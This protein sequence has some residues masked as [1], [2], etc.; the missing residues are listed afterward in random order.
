MSVTWIY[1]TI[2]RASVLAELADGFQKRQALDIADRAADFGYHKVSV[3]LA[4]HAADM[5]L[6]FV[7]DVR[8]DLHGRAQVVAP[9]LFVDHRLVDAPC[10][11]VGVARAVHIQ[12]P[13]VVPQ[14]QVG[15]RAVVGDEHLAVL[16]G[17]HRARVDIDIG[18][19]L[20]GGDR[21]APAAQE[22][23]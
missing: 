1:I 12:K 3:L 16:V 18:I 13:L 6:D 14:V 19:H 23:A 2:L 17:V 11:E 9:T 8:D 5:L 7:G 20:E 15:L 10:G 21:V 22:P 4:P